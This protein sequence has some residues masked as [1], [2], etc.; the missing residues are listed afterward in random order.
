MDVVY[1]LGTG[2]TWD[3]NELR[4]SLRSIEKNMA[5]IRDVY[6]IGTRPA[7]LRN[8][9]HIPAKDT[10]T[11]KEANIRDKVLI[12]CAIPEVSQQF[13]HIH[14]DHLL[15]TPCHIQSVPYWRGSSLLD[16]A[17]RIKSS[18]YRN[19]VINTAQALTAGGR[20]AWNFDLHTPILYDK[21]LFPQVMEAYDWSKCYTVKSLYCNHLGLTGPSIT[22]CKIMSWYNMQQL[23]SMLKGRDWFSIG[24]TGLNQNLRA[25]LPELYNLPSKYE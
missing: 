5:G 6:V 21:D 16:F 12:G 22:D 20:S 17:G 18:N 13:L 11:C 19:H 25:L 8:V 2:S 14:D 10:H 24:P 4:F 7:W 23:V 15:L 1:V 3:D 9:I